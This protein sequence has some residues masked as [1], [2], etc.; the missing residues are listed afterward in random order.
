MSWAQ[1]LIRIREFE[2]ETLRKRLAGV[3]EDRR[4]LEQRLQGLEREC[5]LEQAQAQ[6]DPEAGWGF[7]NFR[8]AWLLR[9]DDVTCK[10]KACALEEEGVRDA[11][12]SA[13]TELKKVQ[14]IADAQDAAAGRQQAAEERAALDEIA[15]RRRA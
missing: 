4:E 6:S 8:K 15:L 11:V 7:V 14:T 5:A 12:S 13:F 1:S 3:L 10:L 9:R 2:I